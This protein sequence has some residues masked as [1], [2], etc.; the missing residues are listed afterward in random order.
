MLG[1]ESSRPYNGGW[2]RLAMTG[3]FGSVEGL[4]ERAFELPV[5]RLFRVPLQPVELSRAVARAMEASARIGDRGLQVANEYVVQLNPRDFQGFASW[6]DTMQREL[7]DYLQQYAL[8]RGW[9]CA[10][11]PRVNLEEG[12]DIPLARPRVSVRMA[13]IAAGSPVTLLGQS[14]DATAV[15]PRAEQPMATVGTAL[16]WLALPDEA[17]WPV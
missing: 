12:A 16:A 13:D 14:P 5:R 7:S 2:R 17:A 1:R 8:Q 4:L 10:G 15:V 6:R 3:P 9:H 11:R